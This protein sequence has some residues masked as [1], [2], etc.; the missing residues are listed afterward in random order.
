M[1]K[2]KFIFVIGNFFFDEL[3]QSKIIRLIDE[4]IQMISCIQ[5]YSILLTT[6][7]NFWNE[8]FT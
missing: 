7:E 6:H 5:Q 3:I 8:F 2:K 4:V 1:K